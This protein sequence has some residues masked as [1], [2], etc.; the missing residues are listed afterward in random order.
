MPLVETRVPSPLTPVPLWIQITAW[1][2]A[3]AATIL[4]MSNLIAQWDVEQATLQFMLLALAPVLWMMSARTAQTS[5]ASNE[6]DHRRAWIC[7]LGVGLV[8]FAT[9]T[10]VG[11]DLERLPPAYHDEYS[12]VFQARTLLQGRLSNPSI[13]PNSEIFDQIHVLNEGRMASRYYPGTGL[14]LAPF[15]AIGHPYWGYWLASAIASIFVFWTGYELGRLRVA[16]VSGLAF[17]LSPG[18]SLFANLLLAHQPTLVG[19]CLFLWS[20]VKWQRTRT[21]LDAFIASCG[22]SYAMLCRPA[23]AA[24]FGLPFG[25]AFAWWLFT[26][27]RSVPKPSARVLAGNLVAM[28]GPIVIGWSIMLAYNHDVT[29]SWTTSPYQLYTDVYSPRHVF[30]FNNVVRGEKKL[31]PKV[32]EAYDR[33]AE[34]LTPELAAFN[35]LNRWLASWIWTFD[36]LPQLIASIIALGMVTRIERR[37]LGVLASIISLH[38]MHVPYWYVGIMGWHYV[39]E[40]APIW[41][42]ILGLATDLL[43][44][45][46]SARGRWL[47]PV[48]WWG[49]LG[50]SL[51]ANYLPVRSV[52]SSLW[53][54]PRITIGLG[55]IRYPRRQYAE[56]DRWLEANVKDRPA[57]VLIQPDPDDQ[58]VDYVVNSPGLAAPILRTRY[59][60]GVTDLRSVSEQFPDRAIY[61]CQPTRKTIQKIR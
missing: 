51:A 5:A 38:A 56:F 40:T 22:L 39:F 59:R 20:F 26:A 3:I 57:L 46:W 47:M 43:T 35:V 11:R 15:I 61:L 32:I 17:A 24:G 8:S 36:L 44:R 60:P 49:V 55:S 42:L 23:T 18:V 50:V 58:H 25:L 30:G 12:Y 52:V 37:W 14:W 2:S 21:P 48:W 27:H 54:T 19:L 33:W 10:M 4:G 41:C 28:G 29:G 9:C 6:S 1:L 53:E 34:N 7:A 16:F 31:G 13:S 45:D